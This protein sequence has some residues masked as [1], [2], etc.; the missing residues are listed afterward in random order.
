MFKAVLIDFDD[1]LCQ[2]E[3]AAFELENEA[4]ALM[5]RLPQDR[6]VHQS[7][8]GQPSHEAIKVRSPG[9][10][11]EQFQM[12]LREL[13]AARHILGTFDVISQQNLAA[14][15]ELRAEGKQLY[16]VTSRLVGE[17]QHLMSTDHALASRVH[18]FYYHDIMEYHKPDPRAFDIVLNNHNLKPDECVYI[19]DTPGDAM[20]AKGAGLAFIA[21]LES[22]L[23]SRAEFNELGVDA[24]IDRFSDVPAQIERLESRPLVI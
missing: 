12:T 18:A 2:T 23:R 22:G 1:T 3:A 17:M 14:L 13:I 8:W 9:I 7:T 16:I 6:A 4:L 15:D 5:G 21:N 20:A 19:G 24:F 11:P 10:D